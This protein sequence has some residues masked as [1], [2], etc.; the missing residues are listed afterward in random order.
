[1]ARV[2]PRAPQVTFIDDHAAGFIGYS[3]FNLIGLLAAGW[4]LLYLFDAARARRA[5]I[6]PALRW[7]AIGGPLVL[8][9]ALLIGQVIAT[10]RASDFVDAGDRSRQAVEDV[11]DQP[12]VLSALGQLGQ[13]TMGF[14]FIFTALNAMR[15]G[16]LTRFMG[17][18]GIIVGVLFVLPF[19]PVPF[20]QTF[21]LLALAPLF[22]LRWP[23]G[24]P[25]AWVTGKAEPWP[26]AQEI[27]D[28]RAAESAGRAE[29]AGL[30]G[31]G[32]G[33]DDPVEPAK[34]AHPSSK[35]RRKRR[36]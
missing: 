33:A 31:E 2:D 8:G 36:R 16:L 5:Q 30:T 1:M 25:P 28:Q 20:V 10:Q 18:L 13:L 27:R 9:L 7:T 14:A 4:A 3:V 23:A 26:T 29:A 32:A 11:L 19:F 17:I 35:K 24:Q 21:W 22:A 6:P 34:P 15:V 12:V